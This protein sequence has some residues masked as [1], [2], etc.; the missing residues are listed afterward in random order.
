MTGVQARLAQ[1]YRQMAAGDLEGLL[2][3]YLPD[4][5]IQSAG[6]PPI[7][8]RAAIREFWRTTFAAYHVRLVPDVEEATAL[9]DVV[10]VR[11]RATGALAPTNGDPPLPVDTWFL[12][13]YRVQA[14]GSVLFWRG[15]NGPAR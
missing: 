1:A 4:A 3:L 8:G 13:V 11:G 5:I 6:Q 9:G 10:V 14:D 7:A 2:T 15:A 12:Q